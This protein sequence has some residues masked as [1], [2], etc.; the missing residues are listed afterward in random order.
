M[1]V[2]STN[3][4]DLVPGNRVNEPPSGNNRHYRASS[5]E[6]GQNLGMIEPDVA[7]GP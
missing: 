2:A 5:T 3:F 7:R 4:A 6:C 1:G